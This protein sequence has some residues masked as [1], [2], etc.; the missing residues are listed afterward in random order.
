[1][2]FFVAP[3]KK[4]GA[5]GGDWLAAGRPSRSRAMHERANNAPVPVVPQRKKQN[6]KRKKKKNK[7]I[8]HSDKLF[9]RLEPFDGHLLPFV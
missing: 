8:N 6:K 5:R 4:N 1:L 3:K 9:R 7:S 2:F